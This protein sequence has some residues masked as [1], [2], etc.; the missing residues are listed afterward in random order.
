MAAF[1]GHAFQWRRF[2]K[3][4]RK[5]QER[6]GFTIFHAKEFKARVNEFSGWSPFINAIGWSVI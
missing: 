6:D 4:L 5:L 1:F 3:K 2:E